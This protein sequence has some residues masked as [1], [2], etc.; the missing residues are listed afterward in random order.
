MLPPIGPLIEDLEAREVLA[1]KAF[2]LAAREGDLGRMD[3]ALALLRSIT[4]ERIV[5]LTRYG[6]E[7]RS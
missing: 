6:Y 4:R 3:L 2:D 7:A 5:I 1:G